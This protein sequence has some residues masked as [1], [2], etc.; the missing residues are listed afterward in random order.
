MSGRNAK[1]TAKQPRVKT[2]QAI[3][4]AGFAY[5]QPVVRNSADRYH[6][7]TPMLRKALHL[8]TRSNKFVVFTRSVSWLE[9]NNR[10]RKG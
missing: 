8:A 2:S 3:S 9:F 1:G 5:P 6:P 7:H 10:A 4:S